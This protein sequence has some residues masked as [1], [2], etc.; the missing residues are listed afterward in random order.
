MSDVSKKKK[1][2]NKKIKKVKGKINKDIIDKIP[3]L[4]IPVIKTSYQMISS[5]NSE[6]DELSNNIKYNKIFN[7]NILSFPLF[8]FNFDYDKQDFEM[9]ELIN[10]AN[11]Y[12]SNNNLNKQIIKNYENK[13]CQSNDYYIPRINNFNS[14]RNNEYTGFNNINYDSNFP[15][16]NKNYLNKENIKKSFLNNLNKINKRKGN[17]YTNRSFYNS[18]YDTKMNRYRNNNSQRY[19]LRNTLNKNGNQ[20]IKKLENLNLY[21]NTNK[22]RPIVYTQIEHPRQTDVKLIPK[23]K[24]LSEKNKYLKYLEKNNRFTRINNDDKAIDILK[25]KI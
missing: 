21:I 5:I 7:K 11:L 20:K 15:I 24:N 10:K 4:D 9:K 17:A 16:K 12:L 19:I 6:L 14:N 3:T 22:R 8:D 25:E 18:L 13:I 2:N 23:M 1:K